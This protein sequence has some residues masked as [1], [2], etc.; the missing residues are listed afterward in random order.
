MCAAIKDTIDVYYYAYKTAKEKL[1]ALGA[2][3]GDMDYYNRV[4]MPAEECRR[5]CVATMSIA[6]DIPTTKFIFPGD[7]YPSKK[8][9]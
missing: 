1:D 6:L 2:G 8:P 3:V 4:I 9:T 5:I 7:P